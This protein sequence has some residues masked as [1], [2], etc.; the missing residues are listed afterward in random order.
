MSWKSIVITG[1]LCVM[2]APAWAVPSVRVTNGGTTG[3]NLNWR[4]EVRPDV[5]TFVANTA[6]AVELDFDFSQDVIGATLNTPFWNVQG[7]NPGNNPFTGGVSE[8]VVVDTV[9]DTVFIA[10]GSELFATSDWVQLATITT[11]SP[12]D[13]TFAGTLHWGG[14]TVTPA[15]GGP[16]YTSSVLAQNGANNFGITQFAV[17]GDYDNSTANNNL[18]SQGD[19]DRVLLQW[20][21]ASSAA[22]ALWVNQRPTDAGGVSQNELDLVLLNWGNSRNTPGAGGGSLAGSVPEPTSLALVGITLLAGG[23]VRRQRNA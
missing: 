12:V 14:R 10:A 1:L 20:G 6:M 7:I 11:N 18:V 22:S 2:A 5:A 13:N 8:G 4:V 21:A 3:T 19:L 17:S 16:T 15:G 9:N 23:L